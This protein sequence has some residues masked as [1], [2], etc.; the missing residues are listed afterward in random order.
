M[1]VPVPAGGRLWRRRTGAADAVIRRDAIAAARAAVGQCFRKPVLPG[2][3]LGR[4]GPHR[5]GRRRPGAGS[6]RRRRSQR[7]QPPRGPGR[8]RPGR[9]RRRGRAPA[10]H[11]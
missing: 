4:H 6:R 5:D 9:G 11:A 8:R 7:R 2:L 10:D 3:P 1:H